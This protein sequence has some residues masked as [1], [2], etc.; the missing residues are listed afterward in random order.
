MEGE[1]I[2]SDIL[3]DFYLIAKE[4]SSLPRDQREKLYHGVLS[5]EELRVLLQKYGY[6]EAGKITERLLELYLKQNQRIE[7]EIQQLIE[8]KVTNQESNMLLY[9][10]G[11][12]PQGENTEKVL[13]YERGLQKSIYQNLIML[14]RLQG[15][16]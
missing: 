16:F 10:L 7:E 13:K 8:K 5:F 11:M 12:A 15:I 3:E 6:F 14:K 4:I 2:S 9:M 1:G